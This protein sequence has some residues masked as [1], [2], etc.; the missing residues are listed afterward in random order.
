SSMMVYRQSENTLVIKASN[1]YISGFDTV[2]RGSA[3]PLQKRQVINLGD[4]QITVQDL[5]PDGRPAT[6]VFE[7]AE[8]LQNDDY[9]WLIWE[10]N[11]LV[12]WDVPDIGQSIQIP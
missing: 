5:T 1:G 11:R 10:S 9:Q 7:F 2:F 12:E 8:P 6:V 3:H 4:L